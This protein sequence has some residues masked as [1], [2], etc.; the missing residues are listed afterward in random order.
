ARDAEPDSM[1]GRQRVEYSLSGLAGKVE[2]R[3]RYKRG[4]KGSTSRRIHPATP[5][6]L[7][8]ASISFTRSGRPAWS[9]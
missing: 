9:Q 4:N 1:V 5:S 7:C 3:Q 8:P 6:G 2:S